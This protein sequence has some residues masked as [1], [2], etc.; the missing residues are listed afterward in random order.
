MEDRKTQTKSP[1]KPFSDAHPETAKDPNSVTMGGINKT[2][3]KIRVT[4]Q[5]TRVSLFGSLVPSAILEERKSLLGKDKEVEDLIGAFSDAFDL[6]KEVVSKLTKGKPSIRALREALMRDIP[7]TEFADVYG[8]VCDLFQT[9]VNKLENFSFGSTSDH[10]QKAFSDDLVLVAE[11]GIQHTNI[12]VLDTLAQSLD[13]TETELNQKALDEHFLMLHIFHEFFF[14]LAKLRCNPVL[15]D[16][17]LT[18]LHDISRGTLS[19]LQLRLQNNFKLLLETPVQ[20]QKLRAVATLIYYVMQTMAILSIFGEAEGQTASKYQNIL[21]RFKTIFALISHSAVFDKVFSEQY[22]FESV[23]SFHK[24]NYTLASFNQK[25]LTLFLQ[26]H[27]LPEDAGIAFSLKYLVVYYNYQIL[28]LISQ[29][30]QVSYDEHILSIF[31]I[32]IHKNRSMLGTLIAQ[33][34]RQAQTMKVMLLINENVYI[35]KSYIMNLAYFS[36][37]L[38]PMQRQA[39]YDTIKDTTID[40]LTLAIKAAMF[41]RPESVEEVGKLTMFE[42]KDFVALVFKALLLYKKVRDKKASSKFAHEMVRHIN[43]LATDLAS[44]PIPTDDMVCFYTYRLYFLQFLAQWDLDSL[45]EK[46]MK[47]S[48]EMSRYLADF[49]EEGLELDPVV[50]QLRSRC[51]DLA[52]E[53]YVKLAQVDCEPA[54][55]ATIGFIRESFTNERKLYKYFY[56]MFCL[57]FQKKV[58]LDIFQSVMRGDQKVLQ[59]LVGPLKSTKE[60]VTFLQKEGMGVIFLIYKNATTSYTQTKEQRHAYELE[61]SAQAARKSIA[62]AEV[63][64]YVTQTYLKK[65]DTTIAAYETLLQD[66]EAFVCALHHA[67]PVAE[68]FLLNPE[69]DVEFY[70]QVVGLPCGKS[71]ILRLLRILGR[72]LE[73]SMLKKAELIEKYV[74]LVT[75]LFQ[76]LMTTQMIF[77]E[78]KPFVLELTEIIESLVANSVSCGVTHGIGIDVQRGPGDLVPPRHPRAFP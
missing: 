54:I 19:A 36:D 33:K 14:A 39:K 31:S 42:P 45:R 17:Q 75:D 5:E 32:L 35:A 52:L 71:L 10:L 20:A 60:T 11:L 43:I 59:E 46:Y 55:E 64:T 24:G 37:N 78:E 4:V 49:E 57:L 56:L 6:W 15:N 23:W 27:K 30:L 9:I 1:E 26:D 77:E 70:Q 72:H 69:F 16:R 44:R 29:R 21:E 58:P 68:Y 12:L 65:L 41:W 8:S 50:K 22:D 13:S 76:G 40:C 63:N 61:V 18:I 74:A 53:Q 38:D 47:Y 25:R 7:K 73:S 51:Q 62:T 28:K 2:Q 34:D 66:T 67:A 3:K 48:E